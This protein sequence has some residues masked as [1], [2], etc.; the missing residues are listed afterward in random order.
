M[1]EMGV[2]A[3]A[4]HARTRKQRYMARADWN[5]IRDVKEALTIP[6]IGN[7]DIL[8][9]AHAVTMIGQTKCDA[10]MI[11]RG[12]KG[13]PHIFSQA[14][15][16]LEG[17]RYEPT[18]AQEYAESFARFLELYQTRESRFRISELQDHARWWISG[19]AQATSLKARIDHAKTK[20]DLLSIFKN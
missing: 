18:S 16:A 13:N 9:G 15:M 11:A 3:V 10:I 20:Q 2:S 4:I 12:A 6:V 17:K 14:L 19:D 1:E 7:G 8:G 5:I